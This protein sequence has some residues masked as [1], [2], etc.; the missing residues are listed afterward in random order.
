MV[1]PTGEFDEEE[2]EQLSTNSSALF[3]EEASTL[4]T[5]IR[6]IKQFWENCKRND[7][8]EENSKES[9]QEVSVVDNVDDNSMPTADDVSQV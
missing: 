2:V 1:I 7:L 9:M 3:P 8:D 6:Q 5:F 4:V